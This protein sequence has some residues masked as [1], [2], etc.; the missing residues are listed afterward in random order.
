MILPVVIAGRSQ[1][2]DVF[3]LGIAALGGMVNGSLAI[4]FVLPALWGVVADAATRT[5]R[6]RSLAA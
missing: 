1:S 3:S 5:P 6:E 4:L 2:V